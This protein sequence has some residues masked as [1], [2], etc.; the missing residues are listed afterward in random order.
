MNI[1]IYVYV[2]YRER[3]MNDFNGSNEYVSVFVS[4]MTYLF[5]FLHTAGWIDEC[6]VG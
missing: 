1:H 6:M 3:R 5:F 4:M 2:Y